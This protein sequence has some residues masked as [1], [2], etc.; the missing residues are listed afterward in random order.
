LI[1][2]PDKTYRRFLLGLASHEEQCSVEEGVLGGELDTL[3]LQIAEDELID[4][5]LLGSLTQEERRGFEEQ[6]LITEGRRQRLKFASAL[7][8][9]SQKVPPESNSVKLKSFPRAGIQLMLSWKHVA[10]LGATASVLFAV[11]AGFELMKLLDQAQ[12]AQESR[13][14]IARLEAALAA[15]NQRKAQVVQPSTLIPRI[16]ELAA[17]RMPV[18]EFSP[19]T[20]GATIVVK[21]R[22]PAEAQSLRVNWDLSTYS[23]REYKEVLFLGDKQLWAKEIPAANISA[24]KRSTIVLPASILVPELIYHLRLDGRSTGGLFEQVDESEFKVVRE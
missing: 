1:S 13:N 5:Y 21:V 11:L 9:Y 2:S 4:D 24:A 3:T 18:I 14:E 7:I 8:K 19:A 17:N 10:F 12:V 23:A 6:F 20:R 16:T 15:D 22:V